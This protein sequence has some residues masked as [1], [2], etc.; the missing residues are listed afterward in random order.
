MA[1]WTVRSDSASDN[2]WHGW[3]LDRSSTSATS[4]NDVWVTW[5]GD[6]G[7][8]ASQTTAGSSDTWVTWVGA[9]AGTSIN[10][11]NVQGHEPHRE[12]DEEREA[13]EERA[14]QSDRQ[15][16]I[17]L[18]VARKEKTDREVARKKAEALLQES[19]DLKQREQFDKTRWFYV[20]G[21]SGKRY[22]IRHGWIGNI[23]EIGEKDMVVAGYCIHPQIQVPIEDSMLIQKL[24]LEGDE[25]RFLEIANKTLHR[26]PH[27]ITA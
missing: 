18:E 3:A 17:R 22:R 2:I 27:P 7:A 21:Q 15:A 1:S 5:S 20:I 23:D 19:L 25:Q 6:T 14:R 26:D 9:S 4:A 16:K 8:A 12:T 11:I 13:R 24:M 10:G